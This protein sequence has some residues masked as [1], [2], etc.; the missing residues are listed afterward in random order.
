MKTLHILG[1][2]AAFVALAALPLG[3]VPYPVRASL[4]LLVWMAWWWVAEP[5]HLAVTAFLP[6]VVL[7]IFNF[8]PVSAILPAY[9][10][11]LVILI[12]GA[13][14]LATLWKRWGLDRRIA[15]VSLLGLGTGTRQHMV[16]WFVIAA[17]LSSVLPNAV[18]SA[19][20]M[21]IVIAMLRYIGIEDIGKSAFGSAL[22]IAV[23]WGTSVGGAGTPL[24]G[25]HN[26]LAV[27]FIERELVD[28][29]FLFTTWVG[30][31]LPL[32]VLL[33]AASA[34]FMRYGLTPEI[35]QVEGSRSYFKDQLSAMGPLSTPERW[36]LALFS[37]ATLLAF[38]RQLYAGLVPGLAPAFVFLS[39][40]IISFAVRYNGQ[41]L[42]TWQ[43]AEQHMVWGLIYL[44][45]GGSALGQVLSDTGAAKFLAERLVPLASDGGFV[46]IA[47]FC[48]LSMAVTQITSNT[49]T[50]AIMVPITISTFQGLGLNPVPFVYLVTIAANCGLALPAASAGPAIAAGYG[51]NL[52]TM[53][54]R[55]IYLTTILWVLVVGF[56]YLAWRFWPGFALA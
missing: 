12:I 9:S 31:V 1:G 50:V 4:G 3:D 25:A 5:V 39:F 2:P 54:I 51:V 11:Q 14:T 53:L 18:V 16:A 33:C 15:L 41:P 43:Y 44:F 20:M 28:H 34:L 24:G 8:M 32:T 45:A 6:I 10:E 30:R 36:G 7:A 38:T 21:P 22:L 49:A 13:N 35:E 27:Q 48:L 29:E 26:L 46:A 19:A 17:I 47:V 37:V 40:A 56:G 42:L 52:K 23:A 55:G